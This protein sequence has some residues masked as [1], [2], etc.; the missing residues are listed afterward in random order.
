MISINWLTQCNCE[1]GRSPADRKKSWMISVY[2]SKELL[3][4]CGSLRGIKLLDQVMKVLSTGKDWRIWSVWKMKWN[5]SFNVRKHSV[6]YGTEVYGARYSLAVS[7]PVTHPSTNRARSCLAS[8]S[9]HCASIGRHR[10]PDPSGW[11]A[12]M[13]FGFRPGKGT[14]YHRCHIHSQ[15]DSGKDPS[16]EKK[17]LW[18]AFRPGES[19][20]RSSSRNVVY[21]WWALR[22]SGVDEWLIASNSIKVLRCS[23]F[24]ETES[25]RELNLLGKLSFIKGR[26][27]HPL[28]ISYWKHF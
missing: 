15:A 10:S 24:R 26:Y 9:D 14:S 16:T 18:M 25:V 7:P 5:E 17:D 28:F 11:H 13:Q 12:V 3:N 20:R 27:C 4:E 1:G 19:I 2:K 22:Q 6:G 8:V 23:N 21:L